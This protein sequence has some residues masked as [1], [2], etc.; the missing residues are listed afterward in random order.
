MKPSR[1]RFQD[2]VVDFDQLGDLNLGIANSKD[3]KNQLDQEFCRAQT[4]VAWKK[5]AA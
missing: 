1:N 5:E 3:T 4:R 2:G